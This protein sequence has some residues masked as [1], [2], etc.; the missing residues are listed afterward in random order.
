MHS[1]AY[2]HS[3]SERWRVLLLIIALTTLVFS[4][5]AA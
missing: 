3:P 1:R 2:P 5:V 4:R